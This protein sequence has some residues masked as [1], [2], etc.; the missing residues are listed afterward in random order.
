MALITNRLSVDTITKVNK[1]D[2][3]NKKDVIQNKPSVAAKQLGPTKEA[4]NQAMVNDANPKHG[5]VSTP[6]NDLY[7]GITVTPNAKKINA[8]ESNVGR[9]K[10]LKPTLSLN[11]TLST[12][13]SD[14]PVLNKPQET[15]LDKMVK[16]KLVSLKKSYP[17]IDVSKLTPTIKNKIRS[18]LKSQVGSTIKSKFNLMGVLNNCSHTSNSQSSGGGSG[19]LN[20]AVDVSLLNWLDC[21]S[22][23]DF[24]MDVLDKTGMISAISGSI[25][26]LGSNKVFDK[27]MLNKAIKDSMGSDAERNTSSIATKGDVDNVMTNLSSSNHTSNSSNSTYDNITGGLDSYDESWKR[28]DLGN[29]NYFRVKDNKFIGTSAQHKTENNF[30]MPDTPTN[31]VTTNTSDSLSMS[32]LHQ[33]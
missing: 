11:D 2:F 7:N 33:V 19:E 23:V 3:E 27:I 4:A 28:D 5:I 9:D 14:K 31:R 6:G 22:V 12:S 10:N 26:K 30:T 13:N 24:A 16:S 32:I 8:S 29:V 17:G 18:G 20:N 21:D 25:G 1:V 15:K